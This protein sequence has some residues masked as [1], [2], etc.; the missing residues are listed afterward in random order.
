LEVEQLTEETPVALVLGDVSTRDVFHELSTI[1]P[2]LGSAALL[3]EAVDRLENLDVIP[4]R[5]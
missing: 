4:A 5:V 2:Q 3:L 1:H